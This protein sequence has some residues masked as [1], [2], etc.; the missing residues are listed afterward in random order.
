MDRHCDKYLYHT[1]NWE[2]EP[3]GNRNNVSNRIRHFNETTSN[4]FRSQAGIKIAGRKINNLRYSDD[5]ILMAEREEKLKSLLMKVK[6]ESEKAGLKLNI[7]IQISYSNAYIQNV[8]K[9]YWRIYLQGSN[10][11]ADIENRLVD[12]VGGEERVRYME[13]VT[14]KLIL[15]YVK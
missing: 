5:T 12:T 2:K 4:I 9:W 8:E 13:R 6:E 7:H 15:S 11:E 14:W 10:G 1:R 3:R